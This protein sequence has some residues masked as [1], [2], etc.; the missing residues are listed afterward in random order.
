[1]KHKRSASCVT[2]TSELGVLLAVVATLSSRAPRASVWWVAFKVSRRKVTVSSAVVR[3]RDRDF[4]ISSS[5]DIL[6]TDAIS[7]C[8][9]TDDAFFATSSFW[10]IPCNCSVMSCK[11]IVM[12]LIC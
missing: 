12:P 9:F 6:S 5:V 4:S 11:V 7:S 2:S 8:T 10:F 1:M 3:E